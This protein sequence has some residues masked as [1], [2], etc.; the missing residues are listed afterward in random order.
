MSAQATVS[1]APL[2]RI[3]SLAARALYWLAVLVIALGVFV[4]FLRN[5]GVGINGKA[6]W[7]KALTGTAWRPYAYRVLLPA[8][9]NFAAPALDRIGALNLGIRSEALLG[10]KFF[11][12]RL[13]GRQYPRQ[14]VLLLVMMYLSLVGFAVG[15]WFLVRALGYRQWVQ[16]VMPPLMLEVS[17]LFFWN[18]GYMYDFTLL[19]LFTL[20]L[21]FML[22]ERW[23]AYLVV[24]AIGTLN[25]E[26]TILLF[27]IFALY[28]FRH[29]QR[30]KF[31]SLSVWQLSLFAVIEGALRWLYR[32]NPGG[33]LEWHWPDQVAEFRL[34]AASAPY[35]LLIWAV[36]ITLIVAAIVYRWNQK[37]LF[38]RAGLVILVVLLPLFVFWAWPLEIRDLL[39]AYPIV[40]VLMI[41]PSRLTISDLRITNND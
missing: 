15:M 25:K 39:E 36:A 27:V 10:D 24:F 37:P 18:F 3:A 4:F 16:Y 34:I 1:T 17:T 13:N 28:F 29:M 6:T 5:S 32:L 2:Q 21:L 38:A 9:A 19:F 23:A 40:A 7:D 12:A 22:R 31:V 41:P 26:T 14:V 30:R 8:L 11:R 35:W 33:S 20:G